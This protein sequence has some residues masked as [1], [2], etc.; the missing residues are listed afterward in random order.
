MCVKTPNCY[1][2][3]QRLVDSK[4]QDL[5]WEF[6]KGVKTLPHVG[7]G[8]GCSMHFWWWLLLPLLQP[9]S[10]RNGFANSL[11]ILPHFCLVLSDFFLQSSWDIFKLTLQ[12]TDTLLLG[13]L[14]KARWPWNERLH[15]DAVQCVRLQPA[16]HECVVGHTL[17]PLG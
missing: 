7:R 9:V 4:C 1:F 10:G 8:P 5:C 17:G 6:P 15:E 14:S 16:D 12:S 2:P 13:R 3:R 11:S